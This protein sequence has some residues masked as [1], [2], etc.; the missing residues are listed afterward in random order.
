[1]VYAGSAFSQ[2]ASI[3]SIYN[4]NNPAEDAQI[5]NARIAMEK[6]E[7]FQKEWFYAIIM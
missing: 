3:I 6:F 7:Y 4:A 5:T 2:Y 1:V